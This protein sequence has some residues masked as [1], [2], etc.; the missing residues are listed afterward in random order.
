[1]LTFSIGGVPQASISGEVDWQQVSFTVPA[2]PQ[3]LVWTYSKDASGTAGMDAAFVDQLTFAP[4]PPIIIAQ[5]VDQ[6]VLGPNPAFMGTTV[7]G[8]APFSYFW[9]KVGTGLRFVGSQ[10]Y[11]IN[12]TYRASSGTYYVVVTNSV[13][14]ATSSNAVL[15]V[16]VPQTV[17]YPLLQPDGTFLVTSQDSDAASFSGNTDLSPFVAQY[18]SNLID[19]LPVTAPL[20]ISNGLMQLNDTDSTNA[21][22]RFYRVIEGW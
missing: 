15:T 5:P 6:T 7:V 2:G 11:Q 9:Y 12:P 20:S 19:W 16:R 18:S 17:A 21:T 1:M 4:A 10:V 13:G 8:A 3:M 14:S 22:M